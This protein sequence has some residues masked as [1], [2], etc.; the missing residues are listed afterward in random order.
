[1][2]KKEIEG[3]APLPVEKSKDK[4][5]FVA[6]VAVKAF[7]GEKHLIIDVYRNLKKTL[8]TPLVRICLTD[9]AFGNYYFDT[10]RW[11]QNMIDNVLVDD[12]YIIQTKTVSMK[13][14]DE[15]VIKRFVTGYR[16]DTWIRRIENYQ[17][18]ISKEKYRSHEKKRQ[19][20]KEKELK[21]RIAQM[22][23][24]PQK[25]YE[26]CEEELFKGYKYIFYKRQGR[27]AEFYCGCCGGYYRYA[28][29]SLDTYEGQFEHVVGIPKS[30]FFGRCE[31]CDE[32]AMYK[33]MGNKASI[34]DKKKCY[35]VQPFGSNGGAVVRYFEIYKT[36]RIGGIPVYEDVEINRSFFMP[37]SDKVQKDYQVR[38][39]FIGGNYWLPNNIPGMANITV[40]AGNLY[41]E[42][43]GELAGTVLEHTGIEE[44]SEEYDYFKVR[45]YMESYIRMP[46]LEM[47]V[48]MKLTYL[49][50]RLVNNEAAAWD[51]VNAQGH[52][53]AEVLMI[54]KKK[55]KKL[56][57]EKGLQYYH[58]LFRMEKAMGIDLPEDIEDKLQMIAIDVD[59]LELM[60]RYMSAKQIINRTMRYCGLT[61]LHDDL[62]GKAIAH[63]HAIAR[64]YA[65]YI[66]MRVQRGYDMSNLIIQYPRNLQEEHDKMV[67]EV[68][69]HEAE[70]RILEVKEKY[71]SIEDRFKEL[72]EIYQYEDELFSVR[73]AK[74][75]AEIIMEGKVLH[76]CVGGDNYLRSHARG[77]STILFLRPVAE[78]RVPFVTI[79]IKGFEIV[80][81][82][83]ANNKK[84][85]MKKEIEKWLNKYLRG[86]KS[87]ELKK[88]LGE[89]IMDIA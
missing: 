19:E 46:A 3:F 11:T 88:N 32:K 85:A 53:A 23:E 86:L 26:W 30:G 73:P 2:K 78:K 4:K 41:T 27:Y 79:E 14:A 63:I 21:E 82:Y 10:D 22:P 38:D 72:C 57:R 31:K 49:A 62:C 18:N 83:G 77:S 59:N 20:R 40:G 5:R 39:N 16:N 37:E 33:H 48:K 58:D 15:E 7:K 81:W 1:M 89:R 76:H 68:N 74:D 60:L 28:T 17:K 55:I 13:P 44:F 43:L 75:A 34:T 70:R 8:K 80:Q 61:E 29:K 25:F 52:T 69:E 71:R 56:I 66:S 6:A 50:N 65:D 24:I 67:L 35:M 45:N 51:S 12:P 36:S 42:N 9:K 54:D 84:T 87:G 47:I 64:T